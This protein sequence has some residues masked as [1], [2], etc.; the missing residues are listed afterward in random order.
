MM[1]PLSSPHVPRFAKFNY[2][3]EFTTFHFKSNILQ[4]LLKSY[5][6]FQ[7][8]MRLSASALLFAGLTVAYPGAVPEALEPRSCTKSS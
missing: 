8:R 3:S 5:Q 1:G 2:L 7:T 4:P 6:I